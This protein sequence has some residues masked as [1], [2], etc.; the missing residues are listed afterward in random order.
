M[1]TPQ[2][3][4]N[5]DAAATEGY[6]IG[7]SNAAFGRLV[8][9]R[10]S[11]PGGTPT[12]SA[13]ILLT[14]PSTRIPLTV[15]HLGNTGGANGNLDG[16]DDR[17]YDAH[18]RNGRLWTAHAIGVTNTGV[19]GTSTRNGSR[20]Y[21][22]QNVNTATP[23]LVQSGTVFTA[24]ASNTTAQK[25]YWFPTVMVS[26][27]G[28]AALGFSTA[29]TNNRANAAYTGRLA[30]DA[31]GTMA[32][33]ADY[34]ATGAAYNPPSDSGGAGGRRWGDYSFT[35]LD[36]DDDM[37][38]WT[39]QEFCDSTNSY[40]VRAAKLLAPAPPPTLTAAPT[41]IANGQPSVNIAITGTSQ[42]AGEGFFD[43]GAGFAKRLGSSIPGVI[44]NS[45]SY[46][47]PTHVTINV[48]TVGAS[49]GSKNVTITNPDGQAVTSVGL[50]TV[51]G[52]SA[53]LITSASAAT[54]TVGTAGSFQVTTS[55]SP[56]PALVAGG[57][58]LPAAVTFTD[59]G[60]GTGTLSGTPGAG[61]GGSYAVTFTAS[62]GTLP[63]GTQ[64][65]TLTVNQA[66]G[67]TSAPPP[68]GAVGAVYA[69]N[70]SATGFPASISYSVTAG[71]LPPGL[72][73]VGSS[74]T[75][76]PTTA[77]NYTGTVTA[78]NGVAP[79]ATQ[80]FSIVITAAVPGAPTAVSALAGNAQAIVSFSPPASDGGAAISS[81]TAT[82]TPSAGGAQTGSGPSS[83][84]TVGSLTNGTRYTCTVHA[85][86]I[87]GDGPESAPSNPVT[88]GTGVPALLTVSVGGGGSGS[89]TSMPPGINC[90]GACSASY[91]PGTGVVLLANPTGGSLF[92]GWLGACIGAAGCTVT[93]NDTKVVSA[94]FAPT[95]TV[96]T[97]DVDLSAPS[98]RYD[99]LSDGLVVLRYLFG[100][101]GASMTA[102]AVNPAGARTDP[103]AIAAYLSNI[104]PRLDIDGDGQVQALTDG[105]LIL[106][107][108]FGLTGTALTNGVI[109]VEATRTTPAQIE[110]YI[111]TLMP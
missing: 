94:T 80:N 54:F 9:R 65:F 25:H 10:V 11:S 78:A 37:T 62:N 53:P 41:T 100:V 74:I 36:P 83:P 49:A 79:N 93:I 19:S 22:I 35:S 101:T 47:D 24:S 77:G 68:G 51:S 89:V 64:N 60:N 20:W 30:S 15:P 3:V 81:Y 92:S 58:A 42:P 46:T 90:P 8:L 39:I 45:V 109:G 13:N 71:A 56:A 67:I 75:G 14:V 86:N 73:L 23:S 52:P 5:Y 61:T 38:M 106:R 98:T 82:C 28:H 110:A 4:D 104:L 69:H 7:V 59:N 6:F 95:G 40:G 102:G 72:S 18:L 31:L 87:A 105:L 43:P 108:L 26:G 27:Q 91:P 88:P 103:T 55:G 12:I 84:L 50:I 96:F 1:Y 21:E 44:V 34:T 85:H 29:G 16:S 97:L 32:S 111:L 99:A 70:Y 107:Y 33:P 17:L 76:T 57:A 2:G 48:S 66:P 63:N